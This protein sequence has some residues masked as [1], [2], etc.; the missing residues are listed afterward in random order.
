M[1]RRADKAP[2]KSKKVEE[3]SVKMTKANVRCCP[4]EVLDTNQL[5][6][7]PQR[8]YVLKKGFKNILSMQLDGVEGRSLICWLLDHIDLESM[9]LRAGRGKELKFSKEVVRLVLG[10]PSAGTTSP[11]VYASAK[12]KQVL[13]FRQNMNLENRAFNVEMMQDRIKSGRTDDATMMCY[14][15]VIFHSLLFPHGSWDISNE[16]VMLAHWAVQFSKID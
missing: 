11:T 6:N 7:K 10:L 8:Q 2:S 5:L 3:K 12:S 1:R 15:I 9:T 14:F 13:K 16:D 4:K